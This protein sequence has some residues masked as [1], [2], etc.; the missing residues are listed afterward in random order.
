MSAK[1]LA[2]VLSV[3]L[4]ASLAVGGLAVPFTPAATAQD[5]DELSLQTQ[6]IGDFWKDVRPPPDQPRQPRG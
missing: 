2:P 5:R 3:S 1:I 4:A 6:I